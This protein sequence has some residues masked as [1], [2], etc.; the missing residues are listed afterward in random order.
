MTVEARIIQDRPIATFINIFRVTPERQAQVAALLVRA[1]DEVMC[2]IP[3]YISSTVHTSDDGEMV[4]NYVQWESK[5]S[6]ME[7][8]KY[9]EAIT[10]MKAVSPLVTWSERHFFNV[11]RVQAPVSDSDFVTKAGSR[12]VVNELAETYEQRAQSKE[13]AHAHH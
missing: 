4:V 5:E 8:F 11:G 7:I 6:F 10:H 9:P 2:R 3:G 1:N 13:D 12:A